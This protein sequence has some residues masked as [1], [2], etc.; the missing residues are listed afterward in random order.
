MAKINPTERL[1]KGQNIWN[2][3]VIDNIDFKDKTFIYGNI[4]DAMRESSHTTLKMA[5]QIRMPI[6]LEE[7]TCDKKNVTSTTGLFGMNNLMKD[8]W[9]MFDFIIDNLLNFQTSSEG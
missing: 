5:F 4:F 6:S 3:A 7:Q 1:I 2:L 9:N 8:T